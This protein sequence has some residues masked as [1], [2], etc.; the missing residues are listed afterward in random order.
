[1]CEEKDAAKQNDTTRST[2]GTVISVVTVLA[3]ALIGV[4][5]WMTHTAES[6]SLGDLAASLE[7][8]VAAQDLR[9]G[10]R[11][12]ALQ[13][14]VAS[15]QT[16]VSAVLVESEDAPVNFDLA[17]AP[18]VGPGITVEIDDSDAHQGTVLHDQDLLVLVNELWAAD[19]EGVAINGQRLS[20]A[21]PI[22]CTGP[23]VRVNDVALGTPFRI[24]AVGDP[25]ALRSAL[26]LPNG[27]VAE[28]ETVGIAVKVERSD[29]VELP[30]AA[31][32]PLRWGD[33]SPPQPGE[34][35]Q[36]SGNSG[37]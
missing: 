1:M 28:L 5:V 10:K 3:L 26:R 34:P 17:L 19:A 27:I 31:F 33:V 37:D 13:D 7:A 16:M 35:G 9:T 20:T 2:G 24:G 11:L 8:D 32:R 23:T 29:R 15:L 4:F 36:D 6:T 22:R 14:Q 30:S 25:D 21:S 12:Q 18:M